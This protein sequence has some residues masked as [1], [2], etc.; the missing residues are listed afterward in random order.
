MKRFLAVALS[1]FTLG[2]VA[3]CDGKVN[4]SDKKKIEEIV[5]NYLLENPEILIEMTQNL[6]EKQANNQVEEDT[7]ALKENHKQIFEDPSSPVLGNPKAEK[8]IVEF[9]DYNCGFC[10]KVLPDLNKF[11][12][13]HDDVKVIFKELPVL[14]PSSQQAA[15]A[16]T[17]VHDIA[18]KKYFE[19]HTAL[20]NHSGA[21]D[22][23]AIRTAAVKVGLKGDEIIT[24][25]KDRK[26]EKPLAE[27][28]KL[29]HALKLNGTPT[30]II[31]GR[32]IRGAV[33]YSTLNDLLDGP[34]PAEEAK[35]KK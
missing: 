35:K 2:A 30:F 8:V 24:K 21:K 33:S 10:R 11:I 25:M 31:N 12:T 4:T 26:Y 5:R 15:L 7:K 32:I 19:F 14:G 1:V 9:F 3:A 27:N 28:E 6:Q 20:M 22:E 17:V 18:P 23:N 34:S 13:E 29:A 16:S